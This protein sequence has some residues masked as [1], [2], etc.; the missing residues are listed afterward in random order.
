MSKILGVAK[1]TY[2]RTYVWRSRRRMFI[3][4]IVE[5]YV[6]TSIYDVYVVFPPLIGPSIQASHRDFK[7]SSY[8][9]CKCILLLCQF[10]SELF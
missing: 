1:I 3:R 5:S 4:H 6:V 7:S 9:V 2:L 8:S 10:M